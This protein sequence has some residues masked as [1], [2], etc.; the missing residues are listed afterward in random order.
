MTNT[1][2]RATVR[3]RIDQSSS[4]DT[5]WSNDMID[6]L[7][8]QGRRVFA[9]ILPESILT[10][11]R[12]TSDLSPTTGLAAYP[13]DYL[14]GL[15]DPGHLVDAVQAVVISRGEK[16]RLK[17]IEGNDNV[18]SGSADK[19]VWETDDGIHCLPTTATT[20]T[21]KYLRVPDDLDASANADMPLDVDDMVVDF[22]F[23]KLMGTPNGDLELA[24]L[25]GKSRG[26][27]TKAVMGTA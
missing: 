26:Y 18:K 22:V 21:F 24:L 17:W 5:S 16:W 13:S 2:L 25:L 12:K 8:D 6:E 7:G 14:R 9:A 4:T 20:I 11:L 27:L 19:Y 15:D 1:S 23:E 3:R 10:S